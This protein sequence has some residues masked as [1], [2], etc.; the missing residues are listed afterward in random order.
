MGGQNYGGSLGGGVPI[1]GVRSRYVGLEG[2]GNILCLGGGGANNVGGVSVLGGS[3]YGG[4]SVMEGG[5]GSLG[6]GM[7]QFTPPR[8]RG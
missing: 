2:G 7:P 5:W 1:L 3:H 4:G 8:G 6:G